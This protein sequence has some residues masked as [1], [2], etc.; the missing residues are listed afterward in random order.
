MSTMHEHLYIEHYEIFKYQGYIFI[1]WHRGLGLSDK[2]TRP[3]GF[4][5][6]YETRE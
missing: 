6:K 1:F 5:T 2:E 4:S 3:G